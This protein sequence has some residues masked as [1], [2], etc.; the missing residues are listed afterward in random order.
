MKKPPKRLIIS[1]RQMLKEYEET[2]GM[3]TKSDKSMFR[4]SIYQDVDNLWNIAICID[5]EYMTGKC[6]L[7]NKSEIE[8]ALG[9]LIWEVAQELLDHTNTAAV[10]RKFLDDYGNDFDDSEEQ[11]ITTADLPLLHKSALLGSVC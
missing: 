11:L 7:A 4:C 1:A 9:D 5:G 8:D 2:T 10:A 6:D 3:I